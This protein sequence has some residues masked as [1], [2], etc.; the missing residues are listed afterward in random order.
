MILL[1]LVLFIFS[2]SHLTPKAI[3]TPSFRKWASN[4]GTSK[5]IAILPFS[6]E[7]ET[8]DLDQLVREGF[9]KHFSVRNFFDIEIEGTDDIIKSL[10]ETEGKDFHIIPPEKLGEFLHC[11]ALVYG[12]VTRFKRIFLLIYVQT[13]IEAEVSIVDTQSGD[14]LW[15]HTFTKR[16]HEGGVPTG[17]FG[18]IPTAIRTTYSL[19]ESKR[20]KDIETF[21]KDLVS[22][23][24]EIQHL[25]AG[26]TNELCAVQVASFK[27]EERALVLSSDLNQY[28]YKPLVR[29]VHTNDETWYRVT[30]GPFVSREDAANYQVKLQSEY[31][32]LN[33]LVVR[34]ESNDI[35]GSEKDKGE[36]CEVRVASFTMEEG[37]SIISSE[38][39]Q[40][41]YKPFL[42]TANSNGEIWHNV[43]LGPFTTRREAVHHQVKLK[44]Q[45]SFLDPIVLKDE[46]RKKGGF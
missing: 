20:N 16:F 23:I 17:P 45:F 26:T 21:C 4:D 1:L 8:E 3:E 33:P 46:S 32:S 9:Y 38:L 37:A 19:R 5:I 10:E 31:N 14:E 27:E 40:R 34:G 11:D 41:G 28:G 13:L 29:K 25:H 22:R 12:K 24:P 18:V 35:P 15:K 36:L 6:N 2:C 42:T 43:M 44:K 39:S 30:V 7:T